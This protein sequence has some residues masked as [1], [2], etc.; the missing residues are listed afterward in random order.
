M[1]I[2][3]PVWYFAP[4]KREIAEI[5]WETL[6]HFYGVLDGGT[7]SGLDN[8]EKAVMLLQLAGEFCSP[9]TKKQVW[10]TAEEYIEPT[11]DQE[12][13]EFYLGLRL[14]ETYPR[15]QWNARMMAGWVHVERRIGL[16]F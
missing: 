13:G 5:G 1:G 7:I 14:G 8:P 4:Q 10:D 16:N 15:G 11:W 12:S 6:A 3:T 2:I 9:S